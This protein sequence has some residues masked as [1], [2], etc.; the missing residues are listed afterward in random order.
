MAFR[1]RN[2]LRW[3]CARPSEILSSA[4]PV[5]YNQLDFGERRQEGGDLREEG[6]VG[7]CSTKEGPCLSPPTLSLGL[8]T[9]NHLVDLSLSSIGNDLGHLRIDPAGQGEIRQLIETG[10]LLK[11]RSWSGRNWRK[12]RPT[13]RGCIGKRPSPSP[14]EP[15]RCGADA[16]TGG[17]EP[18]RVGTPPVLRERSMTGSSNEE[19]PERTGARWRFLTVPTF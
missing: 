12:T 1:A 7:T 19:P 5:P 9:E 16:A 4:G 17:R 11:P 2:P 13:P 14:R 15:G 18:S 3:H 10:R 6:T 8:A